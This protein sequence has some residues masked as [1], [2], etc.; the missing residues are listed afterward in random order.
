MALHR[1]TSAWTERASILVL[2]LLW[3]SADM[4]AQATGTLYRQLHSLR[5]VEVDSLAR[6]VRYFP[7]RAV[8]VDSSGHDAKAQIVPLLNGKSIVSGRLSL[9]TD[10]SDLVEIKQAARQAFGADSKVEELAPSAFSLW[11]FKNGELKWQREMA[12][13]TLSFIPVQ[14]TIDNSESDTRLMIVAIIIWMKTATPVG[15]RAT[16][17]WASVRKLVSE[18]FR[19]SGPITSKEVIHFEDEAINRGFIKVSIVDSTSLGAQ[20]AIESVKPLILRRLQAA[21]FNEMPEHDNG[22]LSAAQDD[23]T[24]PDQASGW[25]IAYKLKSETD[26]ATGTQIVD[27]STAGSQFTGTAI[28]E[29]ELVIRK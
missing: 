11:I 6:T 7:S 5:V 8:F 21:F 16:F 18:Q 13:G 10:Q 29:G 3:I 22:V 4:Q 27:F 1:Q 9:V 28:I 17:D 15:A 24:D 14:F 26:T 23:S 20:T 19:S 2:L 12:G 25:R